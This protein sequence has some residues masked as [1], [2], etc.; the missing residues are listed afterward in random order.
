MSTLWQHVTHAKSLLHN[1]SP[2]LRV[3]KIYP[4]CC[5][6]FVIVYL[7]GW[8][9]RVYTWHQMPRAANSGM[10]L[11]RLRPKPCQT[12]IHR[13]SSEKKISKELGSFFCWTSRAIYETIASH[14]LSINYNK[15][16]FVKCFFKTVWALL[17]DLLHKRA[18]VK[19]LK[20]VKL[21]QADPWSFLSPGLLSNTPY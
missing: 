1:C 21:C 4:G 20:E 5:T 2:R 3:V 13:I 11:W 18:R 14:K 15:T 19:T 10:M 12:A 17:N 7:L 9:H 6:L 8:R 16:I